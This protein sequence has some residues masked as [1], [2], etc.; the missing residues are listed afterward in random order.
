MVLQW[1]GRRE[2]WQG[3]GIDLVGFRRAVRTWLAAGAAMVGGCC[4][5]GPEHVRALADM[6][7]E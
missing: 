7:A 5:T 3:V 4:R 6:A 1:G 2:G